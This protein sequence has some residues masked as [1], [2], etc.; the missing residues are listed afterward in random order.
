MHIRTGSSRLALAAALAAD[1][2]LV[3]LAV[4]GARRR[5]PCSAGSRRADRG[6]DDAAI[7]MLILSPQLEVLRV[8]SA[9]CT[10]VGRRPD[11]LLGH[12]ILEFTH[13]DDVKRS[14]EKQSSMLERPNDGQLI[15]RYLRPD[16]TVV[17]AV[18][19]TAYVEPAAGETE[20]AT[21]YFFSQ[22]Q[23][24]TEQ[25]RGERQKTVIAELG[26][27]ALECPDVRMLMAEAVVRVR[28]T[29]EISSCLIG[30]RQTSGEVHI[31]T[32]TDDT[33]DST[34]PT[35][36]STQTAFTLSASGPV[37]SNDL[38]GE[39]RFSVPTAILTKGI[40]RGLSVP[41]PERSG[42]RHVIVAHSGSDGRPFRDEDAHFLEAVAHV[43][44]G[45]LDRA[46][47]EAELRRRALED[48]LTGLANR[49]LLATQLE[50]E[51]RHARRM[52]DRVSVLELDLDRF[53]S[54]ND[55]LGHSAGDSL[56]R[57]VA[58]RLTGCVREEDLVA[59]PG[60]DEFTIVA[61]RTASDHAIAT[62]AQR[63]VDSLSAP[64]DLDGH[65][66]FV[67]GS[68]GVAVCEHG[69]TP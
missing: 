17:D 15:K 52:D 9:L 69:E 58:A 22:L 51:L 43:L 47:T 63:L 35:W 7:G 31:V 59:R 56:L 45:A 67:T 29:L 2:A 11:Q 18:V 26:H 46:A 65:E 10:L 60:G 23:D 48:P 1:V 28:D 36:Q 50:T 3:P 19:T 32:A 55:T 30:R 44:G 4:R 16:G 40:A 38:L 41:V 61:T 68:I 57:K 24:V 20:D 34:V 13:P 8:N 54:V 37:L 33:V 5:K 66:V 27:R 62:L 64:F 53:K 14:V 12:S 6:F 49:A 25:R 21:P 39:T 42:A